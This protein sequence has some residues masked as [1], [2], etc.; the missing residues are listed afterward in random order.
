MF[1]GAAFAGYEGYT[2]WY[3]AEEC[4]EIGVS[5]R[6][7][8]NSHRA[9]RQIGKA[10]STMD[11]PWKFRLPPRTIELESDLG[12]RSILKFTN[13]TRLCV[14]GVD[15]NSIEIHEAETWQRNGRNDGGILLGTLSPVDRNPHVIVLG[16]LGNSG[17]WALE[18]S[19]CLRALREGL[20]HRL[21]ERR[22]SSA[23]KR[24]PLV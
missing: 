14:V 8:G 5:H 16:I 7:P 1:S 20:E 3:R 9:Q 2:L 19:G 24:S 15:V 10:L 17:D 18:L 4:S 22:R 6:I 21:R 12:R 13:G 23:V 11:R